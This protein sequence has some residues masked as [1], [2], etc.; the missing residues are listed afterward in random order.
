L[1]KLDRSRG[2]FIPVTGIAGIHLSGDNSELSGLK[3]P[4]PV[5]PEGDRTDAV[6]FSGAVFFRRRTKGGSANLSDTFQER[7]G[8][9]IAAV[10]FDTAVQ[11][12]VKIGVK[13]E[14]IL[15]KEPFDGFGFP[16][17]LPKQYGADQMEFREEEIRG[18]CRGIAGDGVKPGGHYQKA[19][20]HKA[21]DK[22]GIKVPGKAEFFGIT[23]VEYD[24]DNPVDI[25][26]R[27]YKEMARF[28][29]M[30]VLH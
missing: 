11:D 28:G 13:T 3:L 1:Y 10:D 4:V 12:A 25:I 30:E 7:R 6:P 29:I 16:E 19:C 14:F 21:G 17:V 5:Y 2:I 8:E 23:G 18:R 9:P 24:I 27:H 20:L 26:P 15:F 22:G